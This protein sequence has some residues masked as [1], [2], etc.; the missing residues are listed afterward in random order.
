LAGD[1]LS[2]KRLETTLMAGKNDYYEVLGVPKD[3]DDEAIKKAYR[4]LAMQ[5]HPDRNAGDREAEDKFREAAEAYEILRDPEKRHRYD[6]YG[7]AGLQG[8]NVPHFDNAQ[9]VFDLF[10]DLLG[11]IFGGG[12]GG[13]GRRG[14]AA[15]RDLETAVELELHEAARG[16]TKNITISRNELCSDCSGSGCRRGTQP[17]ACR[18]CNG[19]GAVLLSQGFFRI[20]QTCNG[21]GGRGVII[22]D[23]CPACQGRCFLAARRS[24]DVAIPPGVDTR[25]QV[26]ISGEGEAGAPGAPRGDLYVSI[27]VRDHT[28]F[29]REGTT[30]ICQ[31]PITFSQAALGADIDVPTLEGIISHAVK[32]GTQSGDVMR[33]PNHGMPSV[34]GGRRGELIVQLLIETPRHLTKRQEELLRELAELEKKNVSPQRKSFLEKL[35]GFFTVEPSAADAKEAQA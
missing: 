32:R 12:G 4:K 3:A 8:L 18:R 25:N 23:P 13:R 16:V 9:S 34:R 15:G 31:V 27:Q 20:Q 30:L 6:R 17:T 14:P 29:R 28:F 24:L 22:T 5:H 26:R 1:W 21:C 7:H 10:G 33:I 2:R 11:D 19:Q 35:K